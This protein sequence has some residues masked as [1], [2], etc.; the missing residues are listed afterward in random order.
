[1]EHFVCSVRL[2]SVI[3]VFVSNYWYTNQCRQIVF[4]AGAGAA[5]TQKDV[6]DLWWNTTFVPGEG[7]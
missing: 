1:M 4:S 5:A 7:K 2:T 6:V 3:A